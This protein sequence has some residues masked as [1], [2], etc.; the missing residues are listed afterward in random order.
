[1]KILIVHSGVIPVKLYGGIERVI[2]CLGKELF[3][4]GHEITYLVGKGSYCDFGSVIH[5]DSRKD[6]IKQIP[7]Y[8][9]F[10]HFSYTPKNILD[11]K[12]PYIITI[13][14]NSNS[15]KEYDLNTV[16]VS[17]NHAARH[18]SNSYVHNGLDWDDYKKPDLNVKREYFHFLGNAAWRVKNV[19]GAIGVIKG[20]KLEK[21]KVLGGTRFNMKMG[22]RLTFSPRIGFCG[23]VGGA[24]KEKLLNSSKGLIFPVRWHEPF[25]LAITESLYFGCPVFGTPYGS[26]PEIV[27]KEVGY[28]SNKKE[29]LIYAVNNSGDFSK[30]L[31]H[32][33][34]VEK[35][36]SK[37]MAL[38]YIE[39]YEKIL[40]KETLNKSYPKLK[41]IQ[42][43]KFLD[44]N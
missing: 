30:K 21:L 12:K 44:W 18:H 32:D 5:I 43:D 16:F 36:N 35:F 14:V 19:K 27:R 33:Y 28:L 29:D 41:E 20:T 6:I 39:K 42:K 9:D 10:V 17:E 8:V 3:K 24:A 26:L 38:S 13:H 15:T 2:W 4:L 11:I 1:M 7:D 25:G 22:L 40:S 37:K 34:A 31:C 23:M